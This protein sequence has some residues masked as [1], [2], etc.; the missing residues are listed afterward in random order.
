MHHVTEYGAKSLKVM[1]NDTLEQGMCKSG[2]IFCCNCRLK[3]YIV[4][5]F[6]D[7]FRNKSGKPEPIRTK[8]GTH[9]QVK[10]RQCSRNFGRDRLSVGEI[11]ATADFRQIRPRNV[12][13]GSNAE[14]GHK[15]MKSFHSGVICP[16]NPKL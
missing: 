6:F 10:G 8:V 1:Q 13:R 4:L 5:L 14:F 15:F 12:N 9:T 2:L 16:Q 11:G 3:A 7:T